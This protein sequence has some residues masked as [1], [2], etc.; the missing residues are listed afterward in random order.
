[1]LKLVGSCR[2]RRAIDSAS[3]WV[4]ML[5]LM[6]VEQQIARWVICGLSM[7]YHEH[8]VVRIELSLCGKVG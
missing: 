2:E 4:D 7:R 3:N 5:C 8:N 1:M 6:S